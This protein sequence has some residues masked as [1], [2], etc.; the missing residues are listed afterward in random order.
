VAVPVLR[1]RELGRDK[2]EAEYCD[3]IHNTMEK[4]DGKRSGLEDPTSIEQRT[5]AVN[6]K[7]E[8][9][10]QIID[11]Y[12]RAHIGQRE[13]ARQI[14]VSS[15]AFANVEARGVKRVRMQTLE[16]YAEQLTGWAE[17]R[18]EPKKMSPM[19][20][21]PTDIDIEDEVSRDLREWRRMRNFDQT[22]FSQLIKPGEGSALGFETFLKSKSHFERVHGGEG[23]DLALY[24]DLFAQPRMDRLIASVAKDA[25]YGLPMIAER[26]RDLIASVTI[27]RAV[28][29][30]LT[31]DEDSQT[32]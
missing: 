6:S 20:A 31:P 28:H 26:T 19:A 30:A 18:Y 15:G 25:D 23:I 29:A 2:K 21:E 1:D 9:W 13:I 4:G 12:K 22:L 32:K 27:V 24:L 17:S 3:I 7:H 11:G 5:D 16:K 10:D 8:L 14:G